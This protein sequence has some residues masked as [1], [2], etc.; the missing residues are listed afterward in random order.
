MTSPDSP[1]DTILDALAGARQGAHLHLPGER[2]LQPPAGLAGRDLPGRHRHPPA[3]LAIPDRVPGADHGGRRGLRAAG[4]DRHTLGSGGA[5]PCAGP[6]GWQRRGVL[7]Q[8]DAGLGRGSV[9]EGGEEAHRHGR[10]APRAAPP[11]PQAAGQ[12]PG[13]AG[14][15]RKPLGAAARGLVGHHRLPAQDRRAP[16]DAGLAPDDQLPLLERHRR[17]PGPPAALHRGPER[18]AR[19]GWRREPAR[20]AAGHRLA[21]QGC[22]RGLPHRLR[23]PRFRRDPLVHPEMDQGREVGLPGRG[24]REPGDLRDGDRP[25]AGPL[26]Q[27]GRR[28]PRPVSHRAGRVEGLVDPPVPHR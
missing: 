26:S 15:G 3:G 7:P 21:G 17:G 1:A 11:A 24:G 13:L 12:D 9:P 14:G 18:R 6:G 2:D 27:R 5:D 8:G 16:A 28:R 22:R 19:G 20:G 4:V 10:R 23:A 25:G